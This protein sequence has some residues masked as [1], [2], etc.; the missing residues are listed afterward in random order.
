LRET[1]HKWRDGDLGSVDPKA[2]KSFDAKFRA[3]LAPARDALT[4]ARTEA[5]ARRVALIDEATALGTKAMERDT[6][7]QVKAIQGRWQAEAKGVTL[8]QRDERALWERFRAACDAVFQAREAKRKEEG[9]K[10]HEGRRVL[11]EIC[12]QTEALAQATDKDEAEQRRAL[13]ELGERWRQSTR[14]PNAAPRPLEARF[15]SAKAAVEAALAARGHAKEAAVWQTLAAKERLCETLDQHVRTGSGDEDAEKAATEP[16]TALPALAPAWEKALLARRDAAIA[17][18][19]DQDTADAYY[20]R[21]DEAAAPRAELL[22]AL[23]IELGLDI[24]PELQAQRLALQVKKLRDRFQTG[25]GANTPAERLVT[26][27]AMPGVVDARD[28]Q[29]VDR[30]FAKVGRTRST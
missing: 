8:L 1:E 21:M 17:A 14:G 13:R 15:T 4:A 6:P 3:A 5:M 27:C 11:E 19:Y 29:R 9:D 10:K 16:W 24:P 7:S 26:W 23:E 28:R 18:F 12:A 20:G 2:W 25:A 30:L 22:L